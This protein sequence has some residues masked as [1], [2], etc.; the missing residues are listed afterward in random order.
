MLPDSLQQQLDL[1]IKANKGVKAAFGAMTSRYRSG[2]VVRGLKSIHEAAAYALAR[3]PST[4]AVL[5]HLLDHID[6]DITSMLDIGAGPGH[7]VWAVHDRWPSLQHACLVEPDV[8]MQQ[9][10]QQ[11]VQAAPTEVEARNNIGGTQA[12]LVI[13]SYVLNE[14]P[15][16]KQQRLV[17]EAWQATDK[18]LLLVYP[19]AHRYFADFQ[20]IRQQL[21]DAGGQII[22]PCPH[23]QKCPIDAGKDWCHFP[24]HVGRSRQHMQV[25]G[26]SHNYEDE[27]FSYLIVGRNTTANGLSPSS[28]IVKKPIQRKG[29]IMLDL[30]TSK[31]DLQR[32]TISK[33]D[34]NYKQAKKAKWGDAL[35]DMTD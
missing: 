31:G 8:H 26:A 16:A 30:C 11:L 25:K 20:V 18:Y 12:D 15:L 9:L 4:Y 10:Q 7:S 35:P 3:L 29:H 27:K 6:N 19:G 14:L 23:M 5:R 22:A 2:E 32:T 13:C 28:R 17:T 1:N 24:L 21:I 34:P 33:S